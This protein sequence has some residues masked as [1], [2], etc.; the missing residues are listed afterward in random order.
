[1]AKQLLFPQLT[2]EHAIQLDNMVDTPS[3]NEQ[4]EHQIY[5]LGL[6]LAADGLPYESRAAL[7]M[8]QDLAPFSSRYSSEQYSDYPKELR[9]LP[10]C[11]IQAY[12]IMFEAFDD[13]L[14]RII[15]EHWEIEVWA[16]RDGSDIK[17]SST[18]YSLE[19]A[20]KEYEEERC[21]SPYVRL[22]YMNE[23]T[24]DYDEVDTSWTD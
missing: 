1:M 19:E 22:M 21:N 9:R 3:N 24:R 7:Q 15:K 6:F 17:Y 23:I 13:C 8:L 2:R 18:F 10:K 4:R 14:K 20:R 5:A 12:R 16:D 11:V